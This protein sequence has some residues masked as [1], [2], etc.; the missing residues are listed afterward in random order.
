MSEGIMH[1]D[2]L[3]LAVA[4]GRFSIFLNAIKKAGLEEFFMTPGPFTV[5]APVDAA[6][7]RFFNI[8]TVTVPGDPFGWL[9]H[10]VL[11]HVVHGTIMI[12]PF[13]PSGREIFKTMT[14]KTLVL[15]RDKKIMINGAR[16]LEADNVC[17]YGCL[18]VIS[19]ILTPDDELEKIP[20]Y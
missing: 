12:L 5:F 20:H 15:Q 16:V 9:K 19:R 7:S 6:F 2:V 1:K 14:G 11:D 4:D 13:N 18:H 8:L 3:E 10:L 17:R